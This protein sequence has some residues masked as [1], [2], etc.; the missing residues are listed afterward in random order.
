MKLVALLAVLTAM[1]AFAP[2]VHAKPIITDGVYEETREIGCNG[3]ICVLQFAKAPAGQFLVIQRVSCMALRSLGQYNF[4]LALGQF[5]RADR[6]VQR[7]QFFTPVKLSQST[8][9]ELFQA[10]DTVNLVLDGKAPAV[11]LYTFGSNASLII[12]CTII[13]HL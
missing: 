8:A 4:T 12:Q 5:D 13:G 7:P 11:S 2:L 9:M 10:N 6:R 1:L 3:D